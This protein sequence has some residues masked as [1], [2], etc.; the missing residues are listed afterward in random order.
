MAA[1]TSNGT[2]VTWNG[3][4][5]DVVS[6]TA[7]SVTVATID[8]TDLES[9][10]RT[11]LGGTIDSGEVS[12][13]IMYDPNSDTDIEDAWDNTATAAPVASNMV[14]TFSD[15]ST[16]TFSAIMTGFSVTLATDAAVTA[17]ATFKISG[18]VT[19]AAS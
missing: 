5:A 2:T 12:L 11:F 14:I 1:I 16:Y 10:H 8:T 18:A 4:I 7:P 3:S 6:I 9:V 19:V 17:S 15:S 13:E